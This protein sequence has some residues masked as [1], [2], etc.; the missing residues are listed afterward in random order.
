[1]IDKTS[2]GGA[3]ESL[4]QLLRRAERALLAGRANDAVRLLE[5]AETR[6]SVDGHIQRQLETAYRLA[7]RELEAAAAH[8]A[9]DAFESN[10]PVLLYNLATG[11]FQHGHRAAEK[12]YRV[13]LQMRPAMASA[14]QN[15]AALLRDRGEWREADEHV[16]L[17]Y[18]QQWVFREHAD[19][20]V[21]RILMTCA[22][23][24]GNVPTDT[25]LPADRFT[26]IKC[27]VNY[28]P[29]G[30]SDVP[31]CDVVFNA[32]GDPDS[33]TATSIALN[34][35][36]ES[37]DLVILNQPERVLATRRDHLQATLAAL[38]HVLVPHVARVEATSTDAE[39]IG[40][41][42]GMLRSGPRIVRC[43]ESHGGDSVALVADGLALE[44]WL[45]EV[46]TRRAPRSIYATQF[47]DSRTDDQHFRKYRVIFI[48]GRPYPY[49]LAISLNWM[50]H[51]FSADMTDA[52]WKLDE[53]RRFLEDPVGSVGSAAW[54][55]LNEIGA[56]LRLDYCGIDFAIDHGRI[57]VFEANATMI[58]HRE[59][60]DGPLAHK[61]CY[62][63]A[64][65][66]AFEDLV[67]RAFRS[68]A[69][70][71]TT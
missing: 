14:H 22:G 63:D 31:P 1:M 23:G 70:S 29:D 69:M 6:S 12:W 58:I 8:I 55:A 59:P 27:M 21:A 40:M 64:I 71:R 26:L 30:D 15:L 34:R 43:A 17:A 33:D 57:L 11:Y 60:V 5:E 16:A 3:T 28:Q 62:V 41:V 10:N 4:H 42:G 19:Q 46:R 50:V 32:V 37:C 18:R 7:G 20:P 52:A 66:T 65:V 67:I 39:V 24:R 51:Y 38:D 48:G 56:R 53:E 49:H 45:A 2:D 68:N 9:A 25:L 13:V 36:L 47:I 35:F 61:N 44:R 54:Q